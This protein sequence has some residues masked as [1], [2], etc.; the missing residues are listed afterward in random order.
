MLIIDD[1]ARKVWVYVLVE[2]SQTSSIFKVG[3]VVEN[4]TLKKV[5]KISTENGREYILQAFHVFPQQ[6]GVVERNHWTVK[7]MTRTMLAQSDLPLSG[8]AINKNSL[9]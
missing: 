1:F 3:S 8:E 5:Q 6:N 2:I 9:H 7:E 4:E